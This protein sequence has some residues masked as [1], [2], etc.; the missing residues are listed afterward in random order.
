M[1]EQNEKSIQFDNKVQFLLERFLK[2]KLTGRAFAIRLIAFLAAVFF[3]SGIVTSAITANISNLMYSD[4]EKLA[5]WLSLSSFLPTIMS[6]IAIISFFI[7][8][9]LVV[10]RVN[11]IVPD[12]QTWPY[13]T[14]AV[15][16]S[17]IPFVSYALY[18]LLIFL[19]TGYLTLEKRNQIIKK[20][21]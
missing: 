19:P 20:Y 21:A 11:D 9:S 4:Y 1:L 16:L 3:I 5:P 8:T 7:T 18:A 15:L 13:A 10:R 6:F 14:G 17:L 2:G 12:T